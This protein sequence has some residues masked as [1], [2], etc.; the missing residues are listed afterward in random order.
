MERSKVERCGQW[1]G[2]NEVMIIDTPFAETEI[3]CFS[4]DSTVI[5]LL[6]VHFCDIDSHEEQTLIETIKGWSK[7]RHK[8]K[9]TLLSWGQMLA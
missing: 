7:P 5:L 1:E 9:E 8:S 3:D 4:L 2:S 6:I